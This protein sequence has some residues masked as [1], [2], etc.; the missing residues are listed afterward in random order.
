MR[1]T[2]QLQSDPQVREL[3]ANIARDVVGKEAMRLD[4]RINELET[5]LGDVLRLLNKVRSTRDEIAT[6]LADYVLENYAKE[7]EDDG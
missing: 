4:Y 1:I 2:K 7:E 5:R 6:V 3:V